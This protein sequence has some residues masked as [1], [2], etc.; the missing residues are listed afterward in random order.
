MLDNV[1]PD[2]FDAI[3]VESGCFPFFIDG[4]SY[5]S[6]AITNQTIPIFF[7]TGTCINLNCALV[8]IIKIKISYANRYT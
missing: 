4:Y 5:L 7:I 3:V 6:K 2:R 1:Y 8:L